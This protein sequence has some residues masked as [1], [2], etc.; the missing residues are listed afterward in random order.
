RTACGKR[1]ALDQ[2]KTAC[3]CGDYSKKHS[4]VEHKSTAKF[5][6]AKKEAAGIHFRCFY[7]DRLNI[8]P[9]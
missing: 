7:H 5:N 3:P 8:N 1:S 9:I 6:K 4:L 2:A